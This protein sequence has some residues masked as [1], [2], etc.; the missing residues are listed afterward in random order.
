M[1]EQLHWLRA[2]ISQLLVQAQKNANP[3]LYGE[4]VLDNMPP[5]ISDESLLERLAGDG[6]WTQL[7]GIDARVSAHAE[8]FQKFRDYALK[9]LRRR[10]AKRA[11]PE[12]PP[13]PETPPLPQQNEPMQLEGSEFE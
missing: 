7:Q 1:L 4:V 8:W 10:I 2:T 9:A 6:W 5:A 13:T 12:P 3:R 11:A